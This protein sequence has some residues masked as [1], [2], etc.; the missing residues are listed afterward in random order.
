MRR[1]TAA[2]LFLALLCAVALGDQDPSAAELESDLVVYGATPG[3]IAAA[4]AARREGLSVLLLDPGVHIGGMMTSGLGASDRCTTSI[5]GG[6]SKEVFEKIGA[7]YGRPLTWHFEPHVAE[8]VF[9]EIAEEEGLQ[10]IRGD[11]LQ[12]VEKSGAALHAVKTRQGKRLRGRIFIDASYEGDLL[13]AAGASYAVGRESADTYGET[14]AGVQDYVAQRQFPIDV[15]AR[16]SDGRLFSGV[17]AGP[18]APLGSGDRK[19]MAYNYRLCLT[20]EPDNM[21]PITRPEVYRAEDYELL[22]AFLQRRPHTLLRELFHFFRLPNRKFDLNNRIA[23]STDFI[24]QNWDYP[25]AGPEQR[26]EIEQRH[27]D[28]LQGLLYFLGNDERVP[29]LLRQNLRMQGLCRDEFA[30]NGHWPYQLYVREARRL[31]GEYVLRERDLL[32]DVRKADS[33]GMASC[34][35]ESHH[36]QILEDEAGHVKFEGWAG[37]RVLPYE[38]PLRSLLPRRS[39]VNNLLVPVAISAS[40]V[41]YS[42][43]RMEPTYMILGTSAGAAAALALQSGTALHELPYAELAAKLQQHGQVLRLK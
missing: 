20:K 27:R 23:F 42:S 2:I 43:M 22:L 25:E 4:V 1:I 17:Q 18:R 14:F 26:A 19:I 13:A 24:G 31:L 41:A 36:V 5:I 15:P 8:R 38:I 9:E 21:V 16:G 30:D 35:I 10:I 29:P 28:Y 34:P 32:Q 7:K 6:F 11:S 12:E 39:E 40:H 3:G 37:K 33:V